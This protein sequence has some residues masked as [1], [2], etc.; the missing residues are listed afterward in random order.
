M[1]SRIPRQFRNVISSGN[2]YRYILSQ[3]QKFRGRVYLEDGAITADEL[4]PDGRH[5]LDIDERSWHVIAVEKNGDISGCLRFLEESTAARFDDLW[6]RRAAVANCPSLGPKI[7]RAV[8]EEMA[9]ARKERLRFGEVGGWAIS[10]NRRCGW[11][12]LRIVLSTYGLLQ[13][14]GGCVGM[15][16]A[17]VRHGSADILRKI[18]LARL[19]AGE[20][21]LAPYYDPQ[22]G[23]PME[24]LRFDSRRANGRFTAWIEE[25][26]SHLTTASVIASG[27]AA[28]RSP[29]P[30]FMHAEIVPALAQTAV[31]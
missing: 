26:S 24:M 29:V 11:E 20:A 19:W 22:Y 21:P 23:C 14:L 28:Y 30:S 2:V 10:K 3:T 8:E 7:R 15:A 16:T 1:G 17:T 31:A 27:E 5:V 6:L 13:Q 12:A 4:S 18:G 9:R 25:L